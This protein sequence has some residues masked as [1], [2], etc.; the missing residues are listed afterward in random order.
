MAS[1]DAGVARIASSSRSA[2]TRPTTSVSPGWRGTR[3]GGDD[4][5]SAGGRGDGV[6][7]L[8]GQPEWSRPD[9]EQLR[10]IVAWA[11]ERNAVVAS[12]ECYA[13]LNWDPALIESGGVPS[14]LSDDVRRRS[15]QP[16]GP[17]LTVQAVEH[18][19]IPRGHHARRRVL[20]DAAIAV[21]KH[22][23][24]MVSTPSWPQ[25]SLRCAI[26]FPRLKILPRAW[27]AN[28]PGMPVAV[29]GE[30]PPIRQWRCRRTLQ[31]SRWVAG[32]LVESWWRCRSQLRRS[33][34]NCCGRG[35]R[36]RSNCSAS[37]H[38]LGP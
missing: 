28:S 30:L 38:Q 32:E 20:M 6:V 36:H 8:A 7:K 10:A 27:L 25:W 4:P 26:Q 1:A 11:R 5:A 22:A 37:Q 18:G 2:P 24:M 19:R 23:G 3:R 29:R 17:L 16:A 35:R 9:V 33:L 12:D 14:P 21:R 31:V 13:A 34:L 15:V